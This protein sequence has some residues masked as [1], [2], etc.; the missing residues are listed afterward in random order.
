MN[1]IFY[2]ASIVLLSFISCTKTDDG[3]GDTGGGSTAPATINIINAVAGGAD[4]QVEGLTNAIP[5][6][7]SAGVD[8]VAGNSILHIYPVGDPARPYYNNS[9]ATSPGERYSLFLSGIPGTT[10]S[11]LLQD[12]VHSYTDSTAGIRFVVL[13]PDAGPV[14]VNIAG[15]PSGSVFHN[16]PFGGNTLFG[17]YQADSQYPEYTFEFRNTSSDSLLLAYSLNTPRFHNVTIVF[18]GLAGNHTLN[19]FLINND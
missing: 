1:K 12:S 3:L 7:A 19:A 10:S 11:L 9:V 4:A 5:Y 2:R 17:K 6:G 15:R 14:S 16:Y 8:V 13:S 18:D